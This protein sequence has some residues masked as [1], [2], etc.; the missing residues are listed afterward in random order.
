MLLIS[1]LF[2]ATILGVEGQCTLSEY[3]KEDNICTADITCHGKTENLMQLVKNNWSC[4]KHRVR[5]YYGNERDYNWDNNYNLNVNIGDVDIGI[6]E[7]YLS[8]LSDAKTNVKSLIVERGNL[9]AVGVTLAG[10]HKLTEFSVTYN[11]LETINFNQLLVNSLKTVNISHN[12][13]TTIEFSSVEST[14]MITTI[15]LSYNSLESIPNNC[16]AMYLRLKYLDLSFNKIENFD[17]LTF[18]GIAQLEILKLSNNKILEIGQNFARF[19]KLKDL[20]L[21]HNQLTTLTDV[22]LRTLIS[23]ERLN[24]SSNMIKHIEDQSLSTL[25]NLE[26]LDLSYNK[27]NVVRKT[28]FK[29]TIKINDLSLSHNDIENIEGGAFSTTNISNFDIKNNYISGSIVYDT[30]LG[31]SV[32][33]LD[34]SNGTIKN[35]GDKAFSALSHDLRYLNLSY[36]LIE[37]ITESA[38]YSLKI[39][40]K[41][42][43]SQNNLIDMEFNTSDLIQLK[44]YYLQNNFIKK[45]TPNMFKNM[46]SLVKLDL[47]QNKIR[48][49]EVNSFIELENLKDL[50]IS[51]NHFVNSLTM[52]LFQ[53]LSRVITLDLSNTRSSTSLNESFSGMTSLVNL[54]LSH[55]QLETIEYETFKNTGSMEVIDLSYNYLENFAINTS[56][57]PLLKELYLNNNKLTNITSET[58]ENFQLLEKLNLAFN[59]ILYFHSMGIKSLSHLHYLDLFSNVNMHIKG[60][61][62]NNL[63]IST[64]SFKNVR[65][66][67]NFDNVVNSSITTLILSNCEISDINSVFVYK[68]KDVLKLDISSNKIQALNKGSFQNMDALNWLDI[69]FNMIS[70]IQPGTF[71]SNKMINTLNLNG[72]NLESLQFGVLDGLKNLRVLNLSNNEIHIFGINL[73]HSTPFLTE[74]Y[75][76]SCK[77]KTGFSHTEIIHNE[78]TNANI[79]SEVIKIK[80]VLGQMYGFLK[81]SMNET[82]SNMISVIGKVSDNNSTDKALEIQNRSQIVF[83]EQIKQLLKDNKNISD[84]VANDIKLMISLL[85][86]N[87]NLTKLANVQKEPS[88]TIPISDRATFKNENKNLT[89]YVSKLIVGYKNDQFDNRTFADMKILLYFIAVCLSIVVMLQAVALTHKYFCSKATRRIGITH[90]YESGQR[91]SNGL[92]MD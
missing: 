35:L 11:K 71:L 24:L 60:D 58:F 41:L 20:S 33:N 17:I 16:F 55:S 56:C 10:F 1:I 34:L 2:F 82:I 79:T 74:L 90:N 43:L 67:F 92:E 46:K 75:G 91:M 44:E 18:E 29:N 57:I 37:N 15:D 36:N 5:Y 49:V 81:I 73:L 69:S 83:N 64:V 87:N 77:G 76:I 78:N 45:V 9:V 39:L 8:G 80:E 25:T 42:D 88:D 51:S 59:N 84:S 14:S 21:D 68:I 40:L 54:N 31:V 13:I 72:N 86:T 89:D 61:A 7:D 65:Q 53:G 30:F 38:F 12:L 4:I 28:L 23:L 47:S 3:A 27:I 19:M 62:F 26:Q 50:N 66:I 52:N 85:E 70:A 22:N 32:E 63:V 6:S 48:D